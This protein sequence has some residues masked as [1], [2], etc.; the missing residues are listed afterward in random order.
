MVDDERL[1]HD[2]VSRLQQPDLEVFAST[3]VA[4]QCPVFVAADAGS[5]EVDGTQRESTCSLM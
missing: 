4:G 2:P 1:I 3:A 5:E